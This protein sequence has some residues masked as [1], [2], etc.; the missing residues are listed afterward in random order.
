MELSCTILL[1]ACLYAAQ[2]IIVVSGIEECPP[3][4]VPH[5]LIGY[6]PAPGDTLYSVAKKFNTSRENLRRRD[7]DLPEVLTGKERIVFIC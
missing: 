3:R 7:N 5:G 1:S 6:F 2:D 4:D